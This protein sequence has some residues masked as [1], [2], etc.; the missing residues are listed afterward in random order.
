MKQLAFILLFIFGISIL[1]AQE[2]WLSTPESINQFREQVESI[3]PDKTQFEITVVN[4]TIPL[5][6]RKIDIRIYKPKGRSL[7]PTLIYVH[8]ACW[9]AGSL[10]SHDEI[11]R[12][13]TVQSN[14]NVVAIDYRL[15]PEHKFPTAHNDVYDA[16]QWLWDN[17]TELGLSTAQFAIAGE[18]TGAYFTAATALKARDTK[19]SPKFSFQLLV[20]A[21][22]DGGGASW[23][24]C[25]DLYF[26]DVKDVRST[27]GSPLWSNKLSGLPP[28]YNIY[29]EYEISRAEEELF[30]RKLKDANVNSQSFMNEGVGHDVVNW[31]SVENV[32]PAHLKAIAYI[33]EGFKLD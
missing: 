3:K 19:G 24:E 7:K 2:A 32:T 18:S 14:V 10:D 13:L 12:Y 17:A 20:Y 27:Y 1:K 30:M 22:L 6:G 11:C 29:G 26:N 9:V 28:T 16:T 31:L 25:K 8:G 5:P 33:K 21:A 23:T 4:K 15:A